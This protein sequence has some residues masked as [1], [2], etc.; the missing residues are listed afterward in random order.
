[1]KKLLIVAALGMP[2]TVN[3]QVDEF[4]KHYDEF[5]QQAEYKYKN[6]RDEANQLYAEFIKQAW[7]QYKT[8]P[9]VPKPKD[10]AT[11]PVVLPDD[12]REKPI[13]TRPVP[14][15]EVVEPPKP[16]PQP[17]PVEP[18]KE[19]SKDDREVTFNV[20]GTACDVRFNDKMRFTLGSGGLDAISEA[21]AQMSADG[22]CNNAIRDCLE[23][24]IRLG[25]SD[26]AYLNMLKNY[27]EAVYGQSDEAVL[28]MAYIYCQSGYSMRLGM[29]SG[30]LFM[31]YASKHNV[32]G[33]PYMQIDGMNFYPFDDKAEDASVCNAFFPGEK[34][35]S[36]LITTEQDFSYDATAE[37]ELKAKA[38]TDMDVKV[39]VNK[40]LIDFYNTYPTSEIDG[41]FMT[42]WAIYA[43]T[44]MEKEVRKKLYPAL[45]NR[46]NGLNEIE[47]M[48]RLLNWVQTAFVYEYDDKVWGEDRAFF[49]EETLFYPY[50]DCEDRAILLTR[51]VRDLLGLDCILIYYPGH[52]AC[53]VNFNSQ[54]NGDYITLNGKRFT[55]C[56]PTY[57]GASVG[58]T[59]P[60][61]DNKTAKVILLNR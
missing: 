1:M 12:D 29:N 9:A 30:C 42:R 58:L 40:N 61:M 37:R 48:Q 59:M 32:Y 57:I 43:N 5:K 27:A 23:L 34:P 17:V 45:R 41:N 31:L 15:E 35:L 13:N 8:L 28:L 26:W 7:K 55:V 25:L 36:L 21:W 19:Q 18:I 39:S 22:I 47:S 56:D 51:L 60:D 50:C 53:A 4:R 33:I 2:L 24:R 46:L 6:F 10:E 38:F 49:A 3:A 52:L 11:P 16:E 54:V 20:F 44:P 14:I